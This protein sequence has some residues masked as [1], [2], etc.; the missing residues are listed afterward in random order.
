MIL[1][2]ERVHF[3]I[4]RD[5][6]LSL[7]FKGLEVV[8]YIYYDPETVQNGNQQ[9]STAISKKNSLISSKFMLTKNKID[10]R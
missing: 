1:R 3:L 2:I 7:I 9:H 10:T 8:T 5:L 4:K 6:F